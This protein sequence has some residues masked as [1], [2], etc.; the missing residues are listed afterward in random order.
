MSQGKGKLRKYILLR[1]SLAVESSVTKIYLIFSPLL[2]TGEGDVAYNP[3]RNFLGA[4]CVGGKIAYHLYN[5][6]T[7]KSD[8]IVKLIRK[9]RWHSQY[10]N[11]SGNK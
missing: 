1:K 11:E 2:D 7:S 4:M 9:S 8:G 6:D 5:F 3:R 10:S